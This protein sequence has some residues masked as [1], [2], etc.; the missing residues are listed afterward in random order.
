[1]A[2]LRYFAMFKYRA[3]H[4]ADKFSWNILYKYFIFKKKSI[5]IKDTI[6]YSHIS[7]TSHGQYQTKTQQFIEWEDG[8]V[9]TFLAKIYSN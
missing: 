7:N 4:E 8:F 1:M 2:S 6:I 9:A 3:A 5:Y